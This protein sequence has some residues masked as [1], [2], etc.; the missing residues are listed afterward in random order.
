MTKKH[1]YFFVLII[2]VTGYIWIFLNYFNHSVYWGGC[3]F[4]KIT[5]I[6]CPSCGTTRS[7]MALLQ[8]HLWEALYFNPLGIIV[9][10]I[11][12]AL[13]VWALIDT[14]T[15]KESLFSFYNRINK[16]FSF[17]YITIILILLLLANWGW[18]I[19]KQL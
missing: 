17:N 8:G 19:Y 13:P 10:L 12:I 4:H 16:H 1:F 11:A 2:C 3:L 18:N 14:I 7:V 6:P 9:L 5:H 15:R